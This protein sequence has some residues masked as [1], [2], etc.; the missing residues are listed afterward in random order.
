VNSS[1]K[2]ADKY[3]PIDHLSEDMKIDY[4]MLLKSVLAAMCKLYGQTTINGKVKKN[5]EVHTE[6]MQAQSTVSLRIHPHREVNQFCNK[7]DA[8]E[9]VENHQGSSIH[10]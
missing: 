9:F 1:K 4:S 7:I 3:V 10:E 2:Q 5:K 8:D 6:V